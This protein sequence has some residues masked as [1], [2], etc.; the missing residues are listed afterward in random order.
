MARFPFVRETHAKTATDRPGQA[1]LEQ[2]ERNEVSAEMVDAALAHARKISREEGI[3]AVLKGFDL[4][5][6]IGPA[7]GPM[8]VM[9]CASGRSRPYLSHLFAV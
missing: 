3:D 5:L 6:I 9:A 2:V 4:N 8:H 1:L 7:D